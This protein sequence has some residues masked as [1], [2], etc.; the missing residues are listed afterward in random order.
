VRWLFNQL[1]KYAM[2]YCPPLLCEFAGYDEK[3]PENLKSA[4][5]KKK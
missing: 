1:L 2:K 5:L 3:H 4:K